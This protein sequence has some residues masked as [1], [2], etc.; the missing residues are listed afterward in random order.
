MLLAQ[1]IRS[2]GQPTCQNCGQS[3][4]WVKYYVLC[5]FMFFF[6]YYAP[7]HRVRHN[8]LIAV[9]CLS[10]CLS[11]CPVP[12]PKLRTEGHR[13]LKIRPHLEVEKLNHQG[14]QAA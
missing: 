4:R 6:I 7:P 12:N 13:N 1:S 2:I 11:V 3:I 5:L 14:H 10:V 9:V 8:A